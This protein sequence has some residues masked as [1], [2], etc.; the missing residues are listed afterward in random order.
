VRE[1]G[2]VKRSEFVFNAIRALAR[3]ADQGFSAF[4]KI[5]YQD[6]GTRRALAHLLED[7]AEGSQLS[8]G[9]SRLRPRC[10]VNDQ[11]PVV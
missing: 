6:A 11:P 7:T 3:L 2:P 4:A 5:P 8:I 1:D 9:G 10:N